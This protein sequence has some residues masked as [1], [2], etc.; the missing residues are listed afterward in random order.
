[1]NQIKL[2]SLLPE[3]VQHM[4]AETDKSKAKEN[5]RRMFDYVKQQLPDADEQQLYDNM[6]AWKY[7]TKDGQEYYQAF[8][9]TQVNPEVV[10]AQT[11]ALAKKAISDNQYFVVKQALEAMQDRFRTRRG[12]RSSAEF[13]SH[14]D[15]KDAMQ[16]SNFDDDSSNFLPK[17][18][19][20]TQG[21]FDGSTG[22]FNPRKLSP[23]GL[24]KFGLDANGK[25][26]DQD[27]I[28]AMAAA[29]SKRKHDY[30]DTI[31]SQWVKDKDVNRSSNSDSEPNYTDT[32]RASLEPY[33]NP[34]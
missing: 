30:I 21:D 31:I 19:D 13:S 29:Q 32:T 16:K 26:L 12:D 10:R 17:E 27:K 23:I 34:S 20:P 22:K 14:F 7:F 4:I 28:N 2:K 11:D 8:K 1:M 5:A 9:G 25:P 33:K 18:L 15:S 24:A 3:S 6:A